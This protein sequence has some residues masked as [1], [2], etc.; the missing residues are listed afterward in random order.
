MFYTI[1][2]TQWGDEGKG[3]IVDW[4]SSK[5]DLI[6]RYQGGNNA[7][8]TI[9]VDNKIYK[10]NLLPSGIINNK[11]CAIG[12]GVVLDPWALI[13]EIN[14]L[15]DQGIVVSPDNL[16]IADNICL[17]LPIH[18]LLDE[19]NETYRGKKELGTTKKGIG[20]AYEDKVGRR[21][22]RICD[23]KNPVFLKQK[24]NN[25]NK[26]HKDKISKHIHKITNNYFEELLSMAPYLK[27]L[28][29]P[30]W[31]IIDEFGKENKNIVFEG[32]QGSML[33]IDFGTYPYVTSSNTIS[34]QIF[35]GTGFSDRKN[36]KILGITKAYTTRVGSGPFPTELINDIGEYLGKKGQEFGTVTKRKRRCGWFDSVLLKK[37]IKLNGI[38]DIVLT[39]LDVLDELKEINVCIGYSIDNINYDYLPSEEFLLDKIKPI[40]KKVSGWQTSTSGINKFNDLP[41]NAKKYI[42]TLEDLMETNISVVSTGPDRKE[43]IDINGTLSNI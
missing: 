43:T 42:K 34:G 13:N 21:A 2:G 11:K 1:V 41:E 17:I 18:K 24:I 26:F 16:Y 10:L 25:L 37:S 20:P 12:N 9:K 14:N 29:V 30:L 31:K 4:I 35:S 33:D 15:K 5:A 32:A 39:K 7:G 38:T 6:V 36:H 28:T 3:K 23:L 40:Y 22:I 8:H 19:I 27:S